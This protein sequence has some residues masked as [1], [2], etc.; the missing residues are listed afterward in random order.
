MCFSLVCGMYVKFFLGVEM[1]V[2]VCLWKPHSAEK[3]RQQERQQ[4]RHLKYARSRGLYWVIYCFVGIPFFLL[5]F[6]VTLKMSLV[7]VCAC[8]FVKFRIFVFFFKYEFLSLLFLRNYILLIFQQQ[9][10]FQE[11]T[12]YKVL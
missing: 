4:E 7:Y 11:V 12:F 5:P 3:E 10:H 6:V 9:F 2:C 1:C 8:V